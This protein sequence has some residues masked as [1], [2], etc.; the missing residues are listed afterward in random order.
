MSAGAARREQDEGSRIIHGGV[1]YR[2]SAVIA[3]SVSDEAIQVFWYS[4]ASLRSQ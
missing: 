1:F 3:R 2:E 4:I